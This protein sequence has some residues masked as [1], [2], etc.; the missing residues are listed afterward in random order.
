MGVSGEPERS[1]DWR[2]SGA[3]YPDEWVQGRDSPLTASNRRTVGLNGIVRGLGGRNA[4]Q[5]DGCRESRSL[6]LVMERRY[7][8]L[9]HEG[10][11]PEMRHCQRDAT[12]ERSVSLAKIALYYNAHLAVRDNDRTTR[13][14][15]EVM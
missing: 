11:M 12:G 5:V 1:P 8:P 2:V 15:F 13:T 10:S 7:V 9:V 4:P 6:P 14:T 3:T